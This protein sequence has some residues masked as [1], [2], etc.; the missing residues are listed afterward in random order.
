MVAVK[1]GVDCEKT[2][3]VPVPGNGSFPARLRLEEQSDTSVLAFA[4]G[5]I[6]SMEIVTVCALPTQLPAVP[7]GVT[8]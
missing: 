2:D 4:T 3:Q 8:V 1:V 7:I 5:G 6:L